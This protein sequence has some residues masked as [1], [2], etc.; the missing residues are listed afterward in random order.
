MDTKEKPPLRRAVPNTTAGL[1]LPP[2]DEIAANQH[3]SADNLSR[4]E[5]IFGAE[6]VRETLDDVTALPHGRQFIDSVQ[7]LTLL[8]AAKLQVQISAADDAALGGEAEARR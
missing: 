6:F 4:L 5:R 2:L 3:L 8:L 7:A 1:R